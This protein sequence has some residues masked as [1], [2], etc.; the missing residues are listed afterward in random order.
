MEIFLSFIPG[1]LTVVAFFLASF[2]A[3]RILKD[4]YNEEEILSFVIWLLFFGLIFGRLAYIAGN[5]LDFRFTLSKWFLWT[6]YPGI[7][8]PGVFIGAIF[9]SWYWTKKKNWNFWIVVDGLTPSWLTFLLIT[10][11]SSFLTNFNQLL[12]P[13]LS[14]LIAT[15]LAVLFLFKNF[16]KIHWYKSGKP[17]FIGCSA[18]TFYCLGLAALD[19]YYGIEVYLSTILAFLIVLTA[20]FFLYRRSEREIKKDIGDVGKFLCRAKL[21]FK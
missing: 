18:I 13:K 6:Q 4:D 17:G 9:F 1:I 5:F 20:V 8:L 16:R 10:N 12:I 14:L 2:I 3:W 15:F 19:F 21:K 11:L 7:S